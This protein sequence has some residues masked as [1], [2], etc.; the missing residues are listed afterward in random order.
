[1]TGRE[2]TNQEVERFHDAAT[3]IE[4]DGVE[5][6]FHCRHCYGYQIAGMALVMWLRCQKL[7]AGE[8]PHSGIDEEVNKILRESG[9]LENEN[10]S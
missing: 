10:P 4:K 1:M 2:M 7:P 9:R 8:W 5:A 6:Y 3:M